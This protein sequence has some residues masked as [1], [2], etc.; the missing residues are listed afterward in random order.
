[1][2]DVTKQAHCIKLA[3][4]IPRLDCVDLFNCELMLSRI[5][6]SSILISRFA[7]SD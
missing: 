2:V 4:L 6:I 3:T 7:W 5:L 1:M